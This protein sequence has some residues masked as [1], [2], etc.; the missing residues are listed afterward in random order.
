MIEISIKVFD[1]LNIE[2]HFIRLLYF[3]IYDNQL[4]KQ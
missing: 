1:K 4:L 2:V 3:T